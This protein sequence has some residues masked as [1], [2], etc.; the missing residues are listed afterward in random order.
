M[1]T[2]DGHPLASVSTVVLGLRTGGAPGQYGAEER[3]IGSTNRSLKERAGRSNAT[4]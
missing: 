2:S 4:A 3:V 1:R